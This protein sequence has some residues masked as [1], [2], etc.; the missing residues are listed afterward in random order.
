MSNLSEKN[1]ALFILDLPRE[2]QQS[3][4]FSMWLRF[5]ATGQGQPC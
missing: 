1:A 4:V 5:T 2:T 3:L